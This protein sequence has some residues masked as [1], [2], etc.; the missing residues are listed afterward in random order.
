MI[1]ILVAIFYLPKTIMTK[2]ADSIRSRA[3][4]KGR[5]VLP[6]DVLGKGKPKK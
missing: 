5:D 3:G 4:V 2:L 6:I 1:K